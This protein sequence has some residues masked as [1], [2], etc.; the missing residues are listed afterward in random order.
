MHRAHSAGHS[1][2]TLKAEHNIALTDVFCWDKPFWRLQLGVW[3]N[4]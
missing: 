1:Y 3:R 4:T 2:P